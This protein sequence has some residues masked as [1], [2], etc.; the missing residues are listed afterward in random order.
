MDP[1]LQRLY[2]FDVTFDLK[3]TE[4]A[5]VAYEM[6]ELEVA[7]FSVVSKFCIHHVSLSLFLSISFL[8]IILKTEKG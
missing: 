1:F 6:R 7:I 3:A 5:M 2:K 4:C 8:T